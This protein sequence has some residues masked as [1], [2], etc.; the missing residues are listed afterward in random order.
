VLL[1]VILYSPSAATLRYAR[2]AYPVSLMKWLKGAL[3]TVALAGA[4]GAFGWFFISQLDSGGG[5][6][7]DLAGVLLSPPPGSVIVERGELSFAAAAAELQAQA[8][9]PGSVAPGSGPGSAGSAGS[10]PVALHFKRQGAEV[11]WLAD[12]RAD[13]LE[14]RAAGASGTRLQTVWSGGLRERLSWARSHGTFD[15]P[16]LP[17][18]ERKNLYH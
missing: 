14:E 18:G 12:V 17:P 8:F 3:T 6:R 1:E 10:D 5:R 9:H 7:D 2:L 4:L 15:A 16:G 11:Y 13:L